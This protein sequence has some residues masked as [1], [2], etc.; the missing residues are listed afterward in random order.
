MQEII[1]QLLMELQSGQPL[2]LVTLVSERGSTP[3][4]A[5]AQMLVRSD[6]SIEGTIGGGLL[7][8]S[9]IDQAKRAIMTG[10]SLLTSMALSCPDGDA[11]SMICG[12][13]ADVLIAFV[14]S[15]HA[16][17]TSI[18]RR[19]SRCVSEGEPALVFTSFGPEQGETDIA[20][21][22]LSDDGSVVGDAL[23]AEEDLRRL[24]HEFEVHGSATLAGGMQV[25]V[26]AI[27]APSRAVICGAGHVARALVPVAASV[28]FQMVV[29][30]DRPAFATRERFPGAEVVVL[31][32]FDDGLADLIDE[33][34]YVVIVTRGHK[35]DMDVLVQALRSPARYIGLMSS[36]AKWRRLQAT[37]GRMGFAEADISRVHA[38]IGLP[39]GAE[40][41]AELAV[42]IVAEL[43]QTRVKGE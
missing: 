10:R 35:H 15:R 13:R 33:Q 37:L 3:R 11:D 18:A 6:A 16:T 22:L 39:I 36:R 9:M 21:C 17:L 5:G 26:E 28:G 12:G 43:I 42:S 41:P 23:G 7:E 34:S 24:A 32:S 8:A 27:K 19:L 14:P 25:Y 40:T 20:Q 38:P 31:D 4:A 29:L 1:D 2:A 30:D